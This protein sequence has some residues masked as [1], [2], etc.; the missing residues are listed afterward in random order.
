MTAMPIGLYIHV[1][2]CRTRCHFCAF[3]LR[4]YRDDLAQA[5]IQALLK[6]ICLHAFRLTTRNRPLSTVYLG[7]GTPTLLPPDALIQILDVVRRELGVAPDAEITIEGT[8]DS[9]TEDG[10]HAL[11]AAGFTRLSLGLETSVPEELVAI[12]RRRASD[13]I[14]ARVG[15]ARR[16]GFTN[17][18]LDLI[19]GLP[20]QTERSW[21][22][23][24]DQALALNPTHVST[25]ALSVEAGSRFHVDTHRG[26]LTELDEALALRLDNMAVQSLAAAGFERY[27][28][29]NYARPG[30]SCRH[31]RLYWEA[32][33]YLGLGPCAQSYVGEQRFSV[34][35][36]LDRYRDLLARG[37]LPIC[38][39]QWLN[40]AQRGK[41][42]LVFGLR[43]LAGVD[44][45]HRATRDAVDAAE[46][47]LSRL[48]AEGWLEQEGTRL[49]LTNLGRQY[50]DSVA[51]ELL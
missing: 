32:G 42:A 7:G 30:F 3:Y 15:H 29:S 26:D 19:Y 27:E 50:A 41:D 37:A 14:A 20:G 6:E 11:R 44:I 12:G 43:L 22:A 40:P 4:I 47:V 5:Y 1:P 23:S 49:R 8:P 25:Y 31:N 13:G 10:L 48:K 35:A 28:I 51:V 46:P 17:L 18:N 16:A 36:D 21:Q 38:D 2:F 45:Q 9:V 24:L 33:D 39:E 34:M